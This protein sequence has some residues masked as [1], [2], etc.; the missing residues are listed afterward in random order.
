VVAEQKIVADSLATLAAR[1]VEIGDAAEFERDQLDLEAA[2]AGQRR[3]RAREAASVAWARLVRSLAWDQHVEHPVLLGGLD[4][5][6]SAA[7][8][9]HSVVDGQVAP[10]PLLAAAIADSVASAER[11]HR[12][13]LAR[14][15]LPSVVA[16]ADWDDPGNRR[17][18]LAVLGLS[19]P[20]PLWQR[21]NGGVALAQAEAAQVAAAT[22]E[23][24]LEITR[25]LSVAAVRVAEAAGRAETARDSLLPMARRLRERA[26]VAYR[27]GETGVIPLLEA[28]RAE[29]EVSADAVDDLLA[30]QEALATWKQTLG[31]AE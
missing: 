17:G 20:L 23:I 26:T 2:R 29:R 10:P 14:V 8:G 24:R 13:A 25:Q 31:E 12:A 15:P 5:G 21:G 7:N 16:G 28:F 6:L 30:F 11:A 1:R 9:M 19:L 22:G 27:A 18:A 3:S 4:D